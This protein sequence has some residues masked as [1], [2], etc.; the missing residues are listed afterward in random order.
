MKRILLIT[1]L[2]ISSCNYTFDKTVGVT[3]D[4]DSNRLNLPPEQISYQMVADTVIQPKCLMCHSEVTG[5]KGG[6]NLET[7]KKVTQYSEQIKNEVEGKTMPPPG[8]GLFL[9]H[10][11]DQFLISWINAGS[12]QFASTPSPETPSPKPTP[13]P[14]PPPATPTFSQIMGQVITPK[15]LNCHASSSGN[16]GG[17]NLEKYAKMYQYRT[18]VKSAISSGS[19]PLGSLAFSKSKDM[20]ARAWF[21]CRLKKTRFTVL[22]LLKCFLLKPESSSA[23]NI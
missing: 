10:E 3:K 5:N 18:R 2:F 23:I 7:Y 6:I 9:T 16:R 22:L 19:M 17:I 21:S 1:G 15:C 8:N 12:K 20:E 4:S 11:E 14:V 13:T